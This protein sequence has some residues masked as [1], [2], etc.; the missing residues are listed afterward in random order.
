MGVLKRYV[1]SFDYA[2]HEMWL[3]KAGGY[4]DP[5]RYDRSGSWLGLGDG[6]A[7]TVLDVVDGGP[8]SMAGLRRGDTVVAIDGITATP[9]SLFALRERLKRPD[10]ATAVF[11]IMRDGRAETLRSELRD[12][13]AP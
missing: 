10:L 6:G 3:D 9:D 2:R 13:I 4:A 5:D 8:A 1:A 7:L 11:D 12:L